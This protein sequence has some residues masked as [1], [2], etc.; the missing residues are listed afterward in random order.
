LQTGAYG[1]DVRV[2]LSAYACEPNK[3]SEPELGWQRALH[4]T[5]YADDVWVLT[6]QNNR[7]VIE[8]DPLSHVSGLHFIYYDLSQWALG[9]KNLA[10]FRPLYYVLWQWGAYR[11]A[12]KHHREHPFDCVYHV[13][14]AS[15][16][17]GSF[18]GWLGV[19]FIVGPIAGGERAP[20]R[21]R[22]S[23]MLRSKASELMRDFG[24]Y[25]QRY[26]PLASHA[27]STANTIFVATPDSLD[28]IRSKWRSKTQVHLGIAICNTAIQVEEKGI[29]THPQFVYAGRLIHWKGIHF[30]IRALAEARR[31]TPSAT[32]TIYGEGPDKKWL[33]DVAMQNGVSDAVVFV[34]HLPRNQLVK[35][36]DQYTA[37]VFPSL[38][39]SG[40]MV[41]LEALA[42]GL[43]VISLDRGG[44]G[45]LVNES[46]G[47]VVSTTDVN[48]NQVVTR[49]AGAMTSLAS[50]PK[51]EYMAISHGAVARARELSWTNLTEQVAELE[52]R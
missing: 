5:K 10:L 1:E 16:K 47:I 14:F 2:L 6:R 17:F 11:S 24:I 49:I 35:S 32:L 29:S 26:S 41:V 3:G 23:M 15:M 30:A 8:S 39:D 43:P 21:L 19:P 50:L 46:C 44:P 13:T 51:Q 42:A 12:V 33:Q 28:L 7:K 31:S 52:N 9:L 4:M 37:F 40:G 18:M 34:G 22:R 48:E 36:L 27:F 45:V 25:F 20:I 38:H